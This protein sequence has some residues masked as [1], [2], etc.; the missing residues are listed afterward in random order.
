MYKN[1][2]SV[3][4]GG[5]IGANLRYMMGEWIP[6]VNGFPLPTL[7]ANLIGAFLLSGLTVM[8]FNRKKVPDVIMLSI[9]TG[10][11]GAFTTFS[12]FSVETVQLL[13][14]EQYFNATSYVVISVV[15]GLICA[16]VGGKL[17]RRK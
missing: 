14:E 8:I 12:T 16:I 1:L 10:M 9:G 6:S 7:L 2:V 5:F 4:V 3:G 11:I 13:R 17:V 15:G